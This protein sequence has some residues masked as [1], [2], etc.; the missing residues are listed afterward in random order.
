MKRRLVLAAAASLASTRAWAQT[1]ERLRKVGV[2]IDGSAPHRLPDV[3]RTSLTGRGW[4]E[5]RTIAFDVRYAD[6]QPAARRRAGGRAGQGRGRH[7]RRPL[8]A[9]GARSD[10]GDQDH[11]HHHGAGR[12]TGG[13]RAGGE[14]QP[15]RRQRH[16][17]HQHGGRA[18]RA[19]PAAPQGHDPEPRPRRRARL[20]ARRL[21]AAF[22]CLPR[23]GGEERR[24]AAR[25]GA[26]RRA[27]RLPGGLRQDGRG[28]RRGGA[29]PGGV[30]FSS[31]GHRRDRVEAAPAHHVVRPPGRGGRRPDLAVGQHQRHLRA[32]RRH[33]RQGPEGRQARRPARR[34]AV[35]LRAGDQP[36]D[37]QGARPYR[38]RSPCKS[39]P[40]N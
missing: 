23:G 8:H 15:A 32:R 21:H 9:R 30:Q 17:R 7:H 10:G 33:D 3:L 29:D 24:P 13:D 12:R 6:G 20:L 19:A 4:V 36:Q 14:P 11:P 26:G 1:P 38:C 22:P 16:R 27:R 39:R 31:R 2:L 28:A 18:G 34:A 35:D 5:G 37:R 40:T 25:S